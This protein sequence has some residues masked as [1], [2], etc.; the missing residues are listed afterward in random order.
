VRQP[1]ERALGHDLSRVRIHTDAEAAR[2]ATVIGASAF[3]NGL[4]ISFNAGAYDPGT[5]RGDRLL[6]HELVHVVQQRG[7]P[8]G[9]ARPTIASP[10]DPAELEAMNQAS[11]LA[12]ANAAGAAVRPLPFTASP[13]R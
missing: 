2:A 3:T 9:A 8:A 4:D 6:A 5:R 7:A 12:E 13:V 1:F 11:R 10:N